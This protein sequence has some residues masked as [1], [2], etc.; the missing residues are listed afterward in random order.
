MLLVDNIIIGLIVVSVLIGMFRGF[1]PEV[2]SIAVWVAAI[3]LAGQYADVV[4]VRLADRIES[5]TLL[6][7]LS[8]GI[9]FI[10]VLLAG[11]VATAIVSMVVKMTGL[12][13]T[14]RL[15]GMAFGLVRGVLVFGVLVT[16][17]RVLELEQEPWWQDSKLIPYGEQVAGWIVS[18]LPEAVAGY[19]PDAAREM[20]KEAGPVVLPRPDPT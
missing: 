6:L 17:A 16:F 20:E 18:L 9:V 8:R 11:G 10:G 14:D 13:G 5:P 15:L 12:S 2:M 19:L 7:W 1:V 4:A 3:W